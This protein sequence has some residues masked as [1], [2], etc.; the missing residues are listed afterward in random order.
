MFGHMLPK[1]QKTSGKSINY[2]LTIKREKAI[3]ING[4]KKP[5]QKRDTRKLDAIQRKMDVLKLDKIAKSV[6][7]MRLIFRVGSSRQHA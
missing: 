3:Q 5:G 6:A 4:T 2:S 1:E 7:L